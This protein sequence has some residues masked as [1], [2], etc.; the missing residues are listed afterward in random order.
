MRVIETKLPEVFIIEPKVFGDARGFFQETW[1]RMRYEDIGIKEPFVQDNL[2]FSTRGV[3]RGLHY[4]NPNT[5]GKLVSVV[6]GEVFDVAVDIRR[7]SP[8]FGEW[9]GVHLSGE[10]H[11]Q[12]WVPPGFAH[13]FCVMSDTVYFTY[14]C[15]GLY[16]PAAEGGILWNDPEVGIE[17]PLQEV[18]LS[19]KDKVYP[20]L[21]DVKPDRLPL[22]GK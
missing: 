22:Y 4:Q 15:T 14:K 1:Q 7:G 17:W 5:Q 10:N 8:T 20:Q 12:L 16:N 11:R 3:L 19:D 13:G 18:I 21:K 2:S 9:V 6:Q